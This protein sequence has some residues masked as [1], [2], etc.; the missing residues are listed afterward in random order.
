[1]GLYSALL[2]RRFEVATEARC[3]TAARTCSP[4]AHSGPASARLGFI[5]AWTRTYLRKEPT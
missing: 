5:H 1:M 4:T 2:Q 3:S